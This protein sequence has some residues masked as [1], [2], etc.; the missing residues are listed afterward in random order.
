MAESTNPRV[1]R[2]MRESF[3]KNGHLRR[4]NLKAIRKEARAIVGTPGMYHVED[5][6]DGY[7]VHGALVLQCFPIYVHNQNTQP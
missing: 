6:V 1:I 3:D 2:W 7:G 5:T 4:E